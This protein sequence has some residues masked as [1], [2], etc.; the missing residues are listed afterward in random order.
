MPPD[1]AITNVRNCNDLNNASLRV[2]TIQHLTIYMSRNISR[3]CFAVYSWAPDYP[4]KWHGVAVISSGVFT[5]ILDT[6]SYIVNE[7]STRT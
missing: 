1:S 6:E 5:Y 2:P 7:K 4:R 3:V